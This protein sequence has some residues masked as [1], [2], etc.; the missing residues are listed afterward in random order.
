MIA[1]EAILV[2]LS[3][4]FIYLF[5]EKIEKLISLLTKAFEQV[6]LEKIYFYTLQVPV[7]FIHFFVRKSVEI[8]FDTL[9]NS[10]LTSE[11]VKF[12]YN[13]YSSLY[14]GLLTNY[15]IIL[16]ISLAAFIAILLGYAI[17]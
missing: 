13:L 8:A 6:S 9:L 5:F 17:F 12:L 14:N 15:L 16:I 11:L 1:N 4:S 10:L 2:I 7:Q 3:F